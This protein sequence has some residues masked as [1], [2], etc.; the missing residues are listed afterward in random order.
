[1]FVHFLEETSAWKNHFELEHFFMKM[2]GQ[3]NFRNKIF[4]THFWRFIK[5]NTYIRTIVQSNL[6]L[7]SCLI[8]NKLVLRDHFLWP[9]CHL[10]YKDKELLALRNIFRATKKFLIAK[11]DCNWKKKY[12]GFRNLKEKLENSCSWKWRCAIAA[13]FQP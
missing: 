4:L 5:S 9:I 6:A 1:M 10:L 13:N 8:R 2:K 11:F 7:R 12:L 3:Y